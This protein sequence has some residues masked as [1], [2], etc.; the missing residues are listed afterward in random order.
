M[1]NPIDAID[2]GIHAQDV[3]NAAHGLYCA[4][5][6]ATFRYHAGALR[7]SF[8]LL[9]KSMEALEAV[10][11]GSGSGDADDDTLSDEAADDITTD[12]D[13]AARLF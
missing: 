1:R 7:K 4:D 2:V 11:S 6:D 3:A 5:T 12:D 10:L 9:C 13:I 8:A